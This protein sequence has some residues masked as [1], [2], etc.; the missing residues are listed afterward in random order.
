MSTF[1]YSTIIPC[2]NARDTVGR[3]IESALNQTISPLEVIVVDD[4]SADDSAEVVSRYSPQVRLI[5]QENAGP[6]AAR[7]RGVGVSSGEWV[8]FLDAD[9]MWMPEKTERQRT[10]TEDPK[11]GVVQARARNV[12]FPAPEQ[13]TPE[14]LWV[15]NCVGLSAAIVRR[16]AFDSVKGFDERRSLISV[17]DYNLW[18]RLCAAGWAILTYPDE[19]IYYHPT[20]SSLSKQL[21]RFAQAG[22]TNARLVG[23]L[24]CLDPEAI[25][26]K[27][28]EFQL[29][30][31]LSLL[32]VRKMRPAR[33]FFYEAFHEKTSPVAL[34][35]FLITFLHP[36]IINIVRHSR[37]L[38]KKLA[39]L[40]NRRCPD[41]VGENDSSR[42]IGRKD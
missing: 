31:G 7:N 9:D 11:V 40:R 21:E 12:R 8:A 41:S 30:A 25:R 34:A 39:M 22:I 28:R 35:L 16:S 19:L 42:R 37:E 2:Y 15:G 1:N 18:F 6:G 10:L 4:G 24:L 32:H 36:S 23:E 26:S 38:K 14:V 17:E 13:I 27:V 3:A 29:D 20:E 33:R 5:R